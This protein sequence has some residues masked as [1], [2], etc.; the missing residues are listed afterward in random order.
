M[1]RRSIPRKRDAEATQAVLLDAATEVFAETGYHGARVD[2]IAE[3]AQVNKRMIYAYFGDKEGLYRK[4]LASYFERVAELAR[5]QEPIRDDPRA[6]TEA[7]IRRYYR[8]MAEHPRFA[9]LLVWE[10]LSGLGNALIESATPGLERLREAL[11]QGV[12]RGAFR[13]GIDAR[14]IAMCANSL[15]L[16]FFL[17]RPTLSV[18]WGCNLS[19][20]R[21]VE[22]NL[23]QTLRLVFDG[24]S[25]R[26]KP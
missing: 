15:V 6:E 24:I 1:V 22:E 10:L 5:T 12:S 4:V 26:R 18:A 11:N 13:S 20:P 16:G 17:Q 23:E 9:R 3:R 14:Q 21:A 25:S 19:T 7:I 2:D 8:V